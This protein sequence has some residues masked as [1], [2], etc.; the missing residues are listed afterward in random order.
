MR[1]LSLCI[2]VAT[3]WYAISDMMYRL[4]RNRPVL[5]RMSIDRD[6]DLSRQCKTIIKSDQ[7]WIEAQ[8]FKTFLDPMIDGTFKWF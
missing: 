3:R 6:S 1:K 8:E 7:F 5:E 2:P 4:L